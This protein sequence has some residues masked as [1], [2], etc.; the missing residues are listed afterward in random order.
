MTKQECGPL[1]VA[2]TLGRSTVGEIQNS[3]WVKVNTSPVRV[4]HALMTHPITLFPGF[5]CPFVVMRH[6][7]VFIPAFMFVSSRADRGR[8]RRDQSLKKGGL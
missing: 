4:I 6:S 8:A 1:T 3:S 5:I 2:S 7:F